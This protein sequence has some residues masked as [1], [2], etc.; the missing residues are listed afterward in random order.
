MLGRLRTNA[1][2]ARRDVSTHDVALFL[3]RTQNHPCQITLAAVSVCR[4]DCT[5]LAKLKLG[6]VT[7][8]V[9][10]KRAHPAAFP[11]DNDR[12]TATDEI[13]AT[14]YAHHRLDHSARAL[15]SLLVQSPS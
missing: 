4:F 10:L 5:G 8:V 15:R 13:F 14:F 2:D 6:R 11:L 12:G 1:I 3:C 9:P 7:L